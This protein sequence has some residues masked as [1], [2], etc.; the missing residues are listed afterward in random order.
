MTIKASGIILDASY[1]VKLC[2]SYMTIQEKVVTLP[3]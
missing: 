3:P 2:K 1:C